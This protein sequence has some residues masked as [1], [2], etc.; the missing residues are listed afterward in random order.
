ML[1]PHPRAYPSVSNDQISEISSRVAVHRAFSL[2]TS[3]HLSF[4][5]HYPGWF[6]LPDRWISWWIGAVPMGMYLIRKYRPDVIW[7]TYPVATAHLIGLSL[8]RMTGIPWVADLRDPMTDVDYPPDP[9]IRRIYHWIEEKTITC[10]T[11]AVITTPGAMNSY[12]ERFSGVPASRFRVI[13]NGYDEENFAAAEAS[14]AKGTVKREQFVLVH[15]GIIYPHERNPVPFFEALAA[16]AQCGL[17]SSHDFKVVLRATAH[18][19]YLERLICQFNI[20]DIVTLAPPIPYQEALAEMLSADGLLILQASNCNDQIPAKLYEYLRTR[21]PI[22]AL[23][24]PAGDTAAVLI[25]AGIDT[26]APLDSKDA[27][28]RELLRFLTLAKKNL[29]SAASM[30][31]VMANSRKSRTKELGKLL[32]EV[33][34]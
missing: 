19:E 8:S 7:S 4:R 15:S 32:D 17:I 31:M 21:R 9:F 24:D 20:K 33:V 12:T 16:L 18:D 5:G 27:I 23:T 30:E 29:A 28:M 13:E 10:C 11:R 22:L 26:I 2:D 14:M 25:N 34:Q 6:A 1:T 3:R